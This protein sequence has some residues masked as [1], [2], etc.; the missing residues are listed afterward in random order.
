MLQQAHPPYPSRWVAH[1]T[2]RTRFVSAP[3]LYIGADPPTST[4]KIHWPAIDPCSAISPDGIATTRGDARKLMHSTF[5]ETY[6]VCTCT[7]SSFRQH[8][9]GGSSMLSTT[10]HE[11]SKHTQNLCQKPRNNGDSESRNMYVVQCC[12]RYISWCYDGKRERS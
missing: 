6:T 12:S 5:S 10:V 2:Y 3:Q 11:P 1:Y 8:L 7:D 4:R 9:P